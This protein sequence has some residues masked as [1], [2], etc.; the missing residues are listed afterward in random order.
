MGEVRGKRPGGSLSERIP[1]VPGEMGSPGPGTGAW[2]SSKR[3][4]CYFRMLKM[5]ESAKF[6]F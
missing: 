4:H 3:K 2:M 6:Y 5:Q 1:R